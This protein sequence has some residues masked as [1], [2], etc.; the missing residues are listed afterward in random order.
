MMTN[1]NADASGDD[2]SPFNAAAKDLVALGFNVVPLAPEKKYPGE[3][4]RGEWKPMYNWQRF[5]DRQ[6]TGFEWEVWKDWGGANI[7][8]VCGSRIGDHQIVAVDIDAEDFD[9][10][11]EILGAL[12]HSPM[13]KKGQKGLTLFYRGDMRLT[14]RKYDRNGRQSLCEILTGQDTRQTVVPPSIHPITQKAYVW[15]RGPVPA[16]DLPELTAED[17]EVLEETL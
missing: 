16:E 14:T 10:I 17:I 5:R 6:P 3:I 9:E 8:V 13:A 15:T 1:S 7:G 4:T 2:R 11:E 12:P